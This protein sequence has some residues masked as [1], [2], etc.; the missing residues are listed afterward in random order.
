MCMMIVLLVI[1]AGLALARFW[2][3][4]LSRM[5][6]LCMLV[7]RLFARLLCCMYNIVGF[8]HEREPIGRT[9]SSGWWLD[10]PSMNCWTCH[11]WWIDGL[12]ALLWAKIWQILHEYEID[13][14][15]DYHE[16]EYDK[17]S[18]SRCLIKCWTWDDREPVTP[19]ICK[20][21][22]A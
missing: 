22:M 3:M 19:T 1:D 21:P 7:D 6:M 18:V 17:P 4:I 20:V 14:L 8:Y 16:R 15:L 10:G 11:K 5:I 9:M 2:Q 13:W 12:M